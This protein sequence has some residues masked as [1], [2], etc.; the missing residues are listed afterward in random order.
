[1][2]YLMQC[3]LLIVLFSNVI[4][5]PFRYDSKLSSPTVLIETQSTASML[6]LRWLN[7]AEQISANILIDTI[8]IYSY[9]M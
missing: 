6:R 2:M 8:V 5:H 3:H 4:F 9:L 7:V 1:M